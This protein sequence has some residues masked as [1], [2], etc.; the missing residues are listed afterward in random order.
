MLLDSID[1]LDSIRLPRLHRWIPSSPCTTQLR[2]EYRVPRNLIEPVACCTAPTAQ[3][4]SSGTTQRGRVRRVLHNFVEFILLYTTAKRE[5]S[6]KG[7]GRRPGEG[8]GSDWRVENGRK[9]GTFWGPF[10]APY[11][12]GGLPQGGPSQSGQA[13][14]P[15][16]GGQVGW[17]PQSG[18]G[19]GAAGPVNPV[20]A[21]VWYNQM[22]Q[23]CQVGWSP[24]GGAGQGAARPANYVGAGGG[25]NQMSPS[26]L[27]S[28]FGIG[29]QWG[30]DAAQR[31]AQP[32]PRSRWGPPRVPRP[33][34]QQQPRFAGQ[35][36]AR[37]CWSTAARV[38]SPTTVR[39][40][41][42]TAARVHRTSE[43]SGV[44]GTV[45]WSTHDAGVGTPGRKIALPTRKWWIAD[46][47][48]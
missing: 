13:G 32:N 25:Y 5:V 48:A 28:P 36:S 19:Q 9:R 20:G 2:R 33:P 22:S 45:R 23:G 1:P 24:Q 37:V 34:Q 21:G 35:Q 3:F 40:H 14:G 41:W 26:S 18:A 38:R 43:S 16:Q 44:A 17:G 27:P 10:G 8:G 39:V 31:G 29:R 6:S 11:P 4:H 15:P 42:S 46:R 30:P 12:R 47:T 7:D